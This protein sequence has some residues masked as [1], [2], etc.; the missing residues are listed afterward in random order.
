MLDDRDLR[1]GIKFKDAD[2]IGIPFRITIGEKSL[3]K[4]NVEFKS[5]IEAD[6][7]EISLK[8]IVDFAI[9]RIHANKHEPSPVS[10]KN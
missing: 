1:A 7:Q 4:G 9:S 10:S 8:E 3:A 2:L 6:S 5:R